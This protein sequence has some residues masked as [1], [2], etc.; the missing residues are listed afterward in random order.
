MP[1]A[2]NRAER[3][4]QVFHWLVEN[5]PETP[6]PVELRVVNRKAP[7][8]KGKPWWGWTQISEDGRRIELY[9]N[10]RRCTRVHDVVETIHHEYAHCLDHWHPRTA[11]SKEPQEHPDGMGLWWV[12]IYRAL[13]D[14]GGDEESKQY[15]TYG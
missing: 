8:H 3:G 9:I 4:W 2:R 1:R 6:K 5:F 10:L 13:Y 12:R 14:D 15:P 7:H 11:K